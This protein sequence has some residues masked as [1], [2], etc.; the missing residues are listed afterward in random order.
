MSALLSTAHSYGTISVIIYVVKYIVTSCHGNLFHCTHRPPVDLTWWRHQMKTFSALLAIC[1]GNSPVT[2]EFPSQ[3][4]VTRS[5]DVFFDLR[6]NKRSSKQS[7]GWWF[8]TP[9]R[10]LW[11]HYN[12]R[13]P[14]RKF[15][16]FPL[17]YIW[18]R[19]FTSNRVAGVWKTMD[20]LPDTYIAGC[21]CARNAENVSRHRL[22]RKPLVSDPGMQHGTGVAHVPWCMSGSLTR[23]G[24]ENVPGIPG[25]CATHNFTYLVRGPSF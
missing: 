11:R 1:T 2:G 6:L 7:W 3:R 21:A 18:T 23:G 4:P 19:C 5:F 9:S 24:G 20:L 12:D 13:G 15:I 25:A 10:S 8:D 14:E 16:D 22:H 17:L